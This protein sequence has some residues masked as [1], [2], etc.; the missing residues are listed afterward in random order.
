VPNSY[1]QIPPDGS[2]KKLRTRERVIGDDTIQEQYLAIG[3]N[4]TYYVRSGPL[5]CAANKLFLCLFNN[6]GSGQ[7]VRIRRLFIQNSQLLAIASGTAPAT[8]GMMEF[9]VKKITG[10]TGGT[11]VTP[12]PADT[13]DGALASFT[14]VHTATS[15]VEGNVLYSWYTNNDE[16]GAIGNFSQAMYQQAIS[17]LIDGWELREYELQPGEGLC[18]KQ[19]TNYTLG[20]FDVLAVL[21]KEL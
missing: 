9:Q 5:A 7:S 6:V 2:G 17:S 15:A 20:A 11:A 4:P 21:T 12:N 3:G 19:I 16:I 10:V 13:T 1:F 8:V 14:A 18:V